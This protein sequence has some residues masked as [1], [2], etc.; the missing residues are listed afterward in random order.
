MEKQTVP[1]SETLVPTYLTASRHILEDSN[2]RNQRH[3]NFNSHLIYARLQPLMLPRASHKT[4]GDAEI[5]KTWSYTESLAVISSE[6][7]LHYYNLRF[8]RKDVFGIDSGHCA[9]WSQSTDTYTK[10]GLSNQCNIC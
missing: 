2:N 6:M 4:S 3:A 1:S 8:T 10:P 7:E 9:M 5:E